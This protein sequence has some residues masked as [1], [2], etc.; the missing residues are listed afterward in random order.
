M[1]KKRLSDSIE[2][3][4]K[5]HTPCTLPHIQSAVDNTYAENKIRED[6]LSS[7]LANLNRFKLFEPKLSPAEFFGRSWIISLPADV[8]ELVRVTVVSLLTDA[9]ER[10]INAQQD[11]PTDAVGNR[12]L[13]SVCVIDEA[14]KIL[15]SKLPGLANLIRLGRSKGAAVMLISQK[16]D[17]FDGEDDDFL[18][19]MGAIV[20]FATNA[21]PAQA[22]RIFG[23]GIS[24]TSLK[25]GEALVKKRGEARA[26][27]VIC[28]E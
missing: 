28:W 5:A 9:L 27:K 24:L 3:A 16:P 2:I 7:N 18:A 10:H 22:Q 17:D 13:R 4:L 21:R 11:A 19:E 20:C 1:Q 14:H 8:P 26:G 12:A 23:S 6:S 15:G 25:T